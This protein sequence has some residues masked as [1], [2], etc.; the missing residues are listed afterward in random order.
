ML[1]CGK[2]WEIATS[3]WLSGD[4]ERSPPSYDE[5]Y[6]NQVFVK[7]KTNR[8]LKTQIWI[9]GFRGWT[10]ASPFRF[11]DLDRPLPGMISPLSGKLFRSVF[12]LLV[13]YDSKTFIS[14]VFGQKNRPC[15]SD[16]GKTLQKLDFGNFMEIV[17]LNST[18]Q[19]FAPTFLDDE[20]IF[21]SDSKNKK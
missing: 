10:T 9:G 5:L 21:L 18:Q 4:S 11:P 20:T 2:Q 7:M 8:D 16:F 19:N 1:K 17:P 12:F 13:R 15:N 6:Y 14:G 3:S